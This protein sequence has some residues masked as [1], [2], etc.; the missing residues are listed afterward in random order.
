MDLTLTLIEPKYMAPLEDA[1]RLYT[2]DVA[3][4]EG[5]S[6]EDLLEHLQALGLAEANLDP[7]RGAKSRKYPKKRKKKA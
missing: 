1:A 4:R 3:A 5:W 2:A 7:K 6:K